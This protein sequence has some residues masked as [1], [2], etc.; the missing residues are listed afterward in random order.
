MK[1]NIAYEIQGDG[2]P[3]IF[4]HGVGSRKYSWNAVINKL[5]NN[6]LCVTYDLRGHG[7]SLLTGSNNFTMDD[8]I[9][10]VEELRSHLNFKKI[11]L[12]G[13]SLGGQIAPSY[14]KKYP[15]RTKSLVMLSTAA[16][17]TDVEKKKI[18]DLVALMKKSG[19]EAVLPKLISRWF[20]EEF[21]KN[22]PNVVAKRIE[23]LK[24]M[25]LETFCRVFLIY[26]NCSMEEWLYKVDAPALVMTGSLDVGCSPRLNKL[27]VK[28]MPQAELKV[29]EGLKH[30]ITI[31]GADLVAKNIKNFLAEKKLF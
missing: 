13:H 25:N 5:K 20:T 2:F 23:M 16:F 22:N 26:A 12:V 27:I 24:Q 21:V 15:E 28:S 7:D 31:E 8:L 29:L 3:I 1:S 4:I 6:Y 18:L 11:N 19:L 30:S 17:R 9:H 14:A 10:D